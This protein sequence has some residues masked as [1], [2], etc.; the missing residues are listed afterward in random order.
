MQHDHTLPYHLYR[1]GTYILEARFCRGWPACCT[2]HAV[3]LRSHTTL[4]VTSDKYNHE[5]VVNSSRNKQTPSVPAI[6][7]FDRDGKSGIDFPR[8]GCV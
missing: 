5:R 3:E 8:F 6:D 7:R 1:C 2:L 4:Q